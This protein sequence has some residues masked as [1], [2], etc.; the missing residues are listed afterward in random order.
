MMSRTRMLTLQDINRHQLARNTGI[1][2]GHIS[3]VFDPDSD[4][5]PSLALAYALSE[6]LD[7]SIDE[8]Y[9]FLSVELA[10]ACPRTARRER[11]LSLVSA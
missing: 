10:K 8:L 3:R 5:W 4:Q 1:D 11:S 9:R 7:V 6:A 2:V